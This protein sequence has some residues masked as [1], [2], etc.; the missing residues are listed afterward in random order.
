M[1]FSDPNCNHCL[2][3]AFLNRIT[4]VK[5]QEK[6]AIFFPQSFKSKIAIF[7]QKWSFPGDPTW[8]SQKGRKVIA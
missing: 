6:T 5:R 8:H 1:N 4:S 3:W 7:G 2:A